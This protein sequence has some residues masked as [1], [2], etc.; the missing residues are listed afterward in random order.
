VSSGDGSARP[1]QELSGQPY[2]LACGIG[3]P[4]GFVAAMQGVAGPPAATRFFADHHDYGEED[5]RNLRALA[6]Q[7]AARAIVV[8]GKDW[9]KIKSLPSMGEGGAEFCVAELELRFFGTDGNALLGQVL[10]KVETINPTR[11]G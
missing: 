1:A 3:N 8:T 2:V 9:V 4:A 7:C 10:A 5:I 6:A 11:R